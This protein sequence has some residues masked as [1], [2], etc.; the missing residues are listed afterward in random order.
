MTLLRAAAAPGE[1]RRLA[2]VALCYL[3]LA[4]VATWPLAP[5]AAGHVYGVGTPPLNIWAMAHVRH[6]LVRHPFS[7]FDGN[8]FHPYRDTLAFSEHLFVPAL[9]SGPAAITGNEVLA[10][11]ATVLLTLAL[12]GLGMYLLGRELTGDAVAAFGGGVLYAFHTWNVNELVRLQI[13]SNQWFPFMV[14][15]LVRFFRTGRPAWAWG[16]AL[17]YAL[18]SLSCMYWAKYLKNVKNFIK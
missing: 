6:A 7:L 11:N 8:A 3:V 13:L 2:L 5:Q 9:L 17:F 10:H 18:Q 1:R 14:L 15:C 12:A 16:T 4:V